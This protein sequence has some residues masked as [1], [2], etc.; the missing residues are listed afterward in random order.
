[1]TDVRPL[2]EI[3]QTILYNP[4]AEATGEDESCVAC[5]GQLA[6]LAATRKAG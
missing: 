1:M 6:V 4:G 3:T 2:R 5:S